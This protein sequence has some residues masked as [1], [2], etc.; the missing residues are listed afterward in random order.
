VATFGKARALSDDEGEFIFHAVRIRDN[1][2]PMRIVA[3]KKDY[4]ESLTDGLRLFTNPFAVAPVDPTI[5]DDGGIR[6]FVADKNGDF[7]VSCHAEGDLCLR[8]VHHLIPA[9]NPP[10]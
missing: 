6:R 5:F 2:E 3:A 1:F 4:R 9:G 7:I 8:L 10:P